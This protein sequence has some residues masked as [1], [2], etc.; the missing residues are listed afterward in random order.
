MMSRRLGSRFSLCLMMSVFAGVGL[1][2]SPRIANAAKEQA[3]VDRSARVA[4][5]FLSMPERGI[6]PRVLRNAQGVAIISVVKGGLIWSGRAGDGV[7]VAR[8]AEGWSGPSFIRVVGAGFGAQVGGKITD[9][10]IVLNTP[11]A[12][13]AFSRGGNVE[14]GGSL[15]AAVGPVGRTAEA[16]VLPAAAVYTYSRSEGLFAGAS[17]EGT[18]LSTNAR[19]NAAYYHRPVS[20]GAILSARVRP[21]A[22]S[23][24]LRHLL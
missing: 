5:R 22:G 7:V 3:I 2:Q 16:G 1:V 14:I 11:A 24:R 18:V 4:Q 20:A 8:T 15:S 23:A 21:P 12:V 17:L 10:V 19:A 13:R 6:P 9:F